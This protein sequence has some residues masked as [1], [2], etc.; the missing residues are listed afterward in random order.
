MKKILA[1]ALVLVMALS[2]CAFAPSPTIGPSNYTG[3]VW[4]TGTTTK[5]EDDGEVT[6]CYVAE[7]PDENSP[8]GI[9]I[10]KAQKAL[11]VDDLTSV[12]SG[13]FSALGSSKFVVRELLYAQAKRFPV[14][15]TF[16]TGLRA[17]EAFVLAKSV[18]GA[19]GWVVVPTYVDN[20]DG[21]VTLTLTEACVYAVLTPVQ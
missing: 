17:G 18:D 14:Q 1:L 4:T 20:G 13:D 6:I 5:D 16:K 21:T 8:Q 3:A 10:G 11:N 19:T 15:A 9:A 2:L 7:E 12:I